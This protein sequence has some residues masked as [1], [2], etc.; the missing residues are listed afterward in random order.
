MRHK[1]RLAQLLKYRKS[2]EDQRRAILAMIE[3]KQFRQREKLFHLREAQRDC[4]RQLQSKQGE[5]SLQISCLEALSH[6]SLSRRKQL[7]E[8]QTEILK[9]REELVEAS[10]SRKIVEKLR[11]RELKRYKESMLQSERK[12]LDEV[13]AIRF[14]RM[15]SPSSNGL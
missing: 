11:D 3:E 4:Q 9:A 7:Q 15:N 8:L 6:E 12:Y 14:S 1:F 10:K 2:I 5:T 13:A